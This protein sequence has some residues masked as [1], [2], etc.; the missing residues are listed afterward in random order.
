MK[1]R[2]ITITTAIVALAQAASAAPDLIELHQ[3]AHEHVMNGLKAVR[4]VLVPRPAIDFVEGFPPIAIPREKILRLAQAPPPGF[5]NVRGGALLDAG[6]AAALQQND[7][8]GAA[9]LGIDPAAIADWANNFAQYT[10][11]RTLD[12]VFPKAVSRRPVIV[13]GER[14]AKANAALQEDL[15]VMM[16]IL[17]KAAGAKDDGKATAMGIDVLSFGKTSGPRVFYIDGYGAM[18]VLNV[19]YP[20]LA[21]PRKD[22]QSQ[23][24]EQTNTEWERAREEVYGRRTAADESKFNPLAAEPFDADRVENL[25]TQIIDDLVNAKNIRSLKSEDHVTVVVLGG[26]GTR[27]AVAR[28]VE[29]HAPA[30]GRA[31][32]GAVAMT[33]PGPDAGAQ[34][35]MTLRS[36]KSDI[37][38]FAKSKLTAE[39]FRK[40]VSVQVY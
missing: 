30:G 37:D 35:T 31:G 4:D 39:E 10:T 12:A 29:A 24:N 28:R 1:T 18:F 17:E 21:P 16:R 40:K 26:G 2:I 34:T 19:K 5:V 36:K 15:T 38:A 7:P 6:D 11:E 32:F 25:K 9:A 20:L 13:G 27:M 33:S 23:T 14:D 3:R 22:E 8:A